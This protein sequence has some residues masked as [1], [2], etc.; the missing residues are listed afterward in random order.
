MANCPNCGAKIPFWSVKAECKQCGVSIPNFNW[1]ERLEEDNKNAE[2]K[3][4]VF[5]KTINRM[6][7]SLFGTKLRIARLILTFLPAIGFILPWATVQSAGD[8]FQLTLFSFTGCKSALD[9]FLQIFSNFSL[10][11]ANMGFEG[12]SGPV[13]MLF[14]GT[15]F[16]FLSALFIVIAFFL[17]IIKCAKPKT[18]STVTCDIISIVFSIVSVVLFCCASGAG[19]DVQAFSIGEFTA[20]DIS[21][22]FTWGYIP[23]LILLLV[24]MGINI[25]VA[26]APAKTDEEL[27][28]ERLE[29]VA[30]KEQKE[31]EEELRKAKER[32]EA[33]KAA[34]EEQK[35]V[36]A[37]AKRKLAEQKAK[38]EAKANKK[39]K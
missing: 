16:Y 30:A 13:T 28:N 2:A 32:E 25:A 10:I 14:A 1:V 24:A 15:I 39:K 35:Q 19:A 38:E 3:F 34:E 27:E 36:V 23:A 18:K 12:F 4:L 21:G 7:Y 20:I 9:I 33:A 26:I 22:G 31:R 11:S 29:R 17:N 37:E 5:N 8:C 6:R